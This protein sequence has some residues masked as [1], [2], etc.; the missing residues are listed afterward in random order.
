MTISNNGQHLHSAHTPSL[1][2]L[3]DDAY[4]LI[5]ILH[6]VATVLCCA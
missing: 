2:V 6:E 3:S 5:Q 4:L 1:I